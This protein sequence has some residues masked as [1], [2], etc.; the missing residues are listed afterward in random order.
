METGGHVSEKS[1]IWEGETIWE[2]RRKKNQNKYNIVDILRE[3]TGEQNDCTG[4]RKNMKKKH[5]QF[6]SS[7]YAHKCRCNPTK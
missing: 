4:N 2:S 5:I 3:R 7:E 6:I 1:D